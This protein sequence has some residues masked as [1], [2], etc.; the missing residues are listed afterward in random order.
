MLLYSIYLALVNT[1]LQMHVSQTQHR[2][3][4]DGASSV[5]V[6]SNQL[7][8]ST[9]YTHTHPHSPTLTHTHTL[10]DHQWVSHTLYRWCTLHALNN[11][12]QSVFPHKTCHKLKIH[13]DKRHTTLHYNSVTLRS[14]NVL[15]MA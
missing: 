14:V 4:N 9:S 11:N 15:L 10:S 12:I 5:L 2:V 1:T 3:R 7:M 6:R 8:L 13:A